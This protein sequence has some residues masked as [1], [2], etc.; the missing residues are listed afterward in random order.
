[1]PAPD[2]RHRARSRPDNH[3][4]EDSVNGDIAYRRRRTIATTDTYADAE[5]VVDRLAED[6]FAVEHVTILGRD[7]RFVEPVTGHV[8]A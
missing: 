3:H 6:G 4:E 5:A 7:L 2:A 8:N 1:M